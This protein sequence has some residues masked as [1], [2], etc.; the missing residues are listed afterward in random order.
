MDL[1]TLLL[2][3]IEANPLQLLLIIGVIAAFTVYV[4][5]RSRS[6]RLKDRQKNADN[7]QTLR[8]ELEGKIRLSEIDLE[9]NR[10]ER[11]RL[12]LT[13]KDAESVRNDTTMNRFATAIE[14]LTAVSSQATAATNKMA[15]AAEGTTRLLEV[16]LKG[17]E[18]NRKV[19]T[20][21]RDT[22]LRNSALIGDIERN[23]KAGMDAL[24]A[25]LDTQ[26]AT[27]TAANAETV[28][29]L[30][31]EIRQSETDTGTAIA[32]ATKTIL[33]DV[34]KGQSTTQSMLAL[35]KELKQMLGQNGRAA[36]IDE[37]AGLAIEIRDMLNDVTKHIKAGDTGNLPAL[38]QHAVTAS[39]AEPMAHVAK[40]DT[41]KLPPAPE[42]NVIEVTLPTTLID[43]KDKPDQLSG[44][45]PHA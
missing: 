41:S 42:T 28:R 39:H 20:E 36:E 40:H 23:N 30:T 37:I 2:K 16:I 35:L 4:V 1:I 24:S 17:L 18:E 43:A 29:T 31:T 3:A 33:A 21:S 13:L 10:Q 12:S 6:E 22:H 8:E 26:S 11:E 14:A 15:T 45:T 19:Q 44:D 38:P 5:Q 27:L 9:R 34:D 25:K 32:E 7:L